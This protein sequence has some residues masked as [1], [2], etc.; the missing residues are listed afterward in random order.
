MMI[1][2]IAI[3]PMKFSLNLSKDPAQLR[4]NVDNLMRLTSEID[5]AKLT[6]V[7]KDAF[8]RISVNLDSLN[9]RMTG[10]KYFQPDWHSG[11]NEYP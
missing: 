11:F 7:E 6:S 8:H 2:L 5:T 9:H 4:H 1:I 10:C 3:V